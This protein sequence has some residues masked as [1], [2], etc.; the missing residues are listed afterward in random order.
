VNLG[1]HAGDDPEKTRKLMPSPQ[2]T[3]GPASTPENDETVV[4]FV[5]AFYSHR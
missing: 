2:H 3:A 5:S 1:I 4:L